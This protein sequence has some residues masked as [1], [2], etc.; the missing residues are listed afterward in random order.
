MYLNVTHFLSYS[1]ARYEG[2]SL[3]NWLQTL[4]TGS[5]LILP[6]PAKFEENW[7][8]RTGDMDR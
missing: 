1:N 6:R 5:T 8:I 3:S 2:F 7:S 4:C